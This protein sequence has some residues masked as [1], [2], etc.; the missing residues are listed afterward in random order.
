MFV[1]NGDLYVGG[2][3]DTAGGIPV[4]NIAKWDGTSWSSVDVGVWGAIAG[5]ESSGA[6]AAYD[7]SLYVGGRFDTAGGLPARDIA[8]WTTPSSIAVLSNSFHCEIFPNPNNGSFTLSLS[9]INEKCNIEIYNMLGEKVLTETL[10]S[11]QGDNLIN[12]AGQPNG[13]YLGRVISETG[14]LVGEGKVI[15]DR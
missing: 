4:K 10:R 12:L 14:A 5:N 2:H 13:V 3:F 1:Y 6:F 15:I 11:T 8:K 9:N 7:S